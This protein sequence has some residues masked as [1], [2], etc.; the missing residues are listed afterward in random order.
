MLCLSG[1]VIANR[2]QKDCCI[3]SPFSFRNQVHFMDEIYLKIPTEEDQDAVWAFRQ[4]LLDAGQSFDGCSGLNRQPTYEDW[5]ALVRRFPDP[6][7]C[8]VGKVPSTTYLGIRKSDGCL[9]GII[10]LRHHIDHPTLSLWGGHIGY[11][12]RPSQQRKGYAKQMLRLNLKNAQKLGLTRVMITCY[13]G[14]IASERTIC[15]C[16]GQYE[17]TVMAEGQQIKRYWIELEGSPCL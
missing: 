9:V 4:E 3:S 15:A 16:G 2:R 8:P 13:A 6:A 11:S 12:V 1:A 5:L 17:K 10:D 14:N 7:S